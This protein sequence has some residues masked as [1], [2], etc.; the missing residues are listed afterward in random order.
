[1]IKM[2]RLCALNFKNSRSPRK[3]KLMMTLAG[4]TEEIKS[5]RKHLSPKLKHD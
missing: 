5:A 3:E 2:T 4:E 1:M